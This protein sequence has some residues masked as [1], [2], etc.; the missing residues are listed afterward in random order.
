VALRTGGHVFHFVHD[1]PGI[2]RLAREEDGAFAERYR[3]V[4]NRS[5]RMAHLA[6]S[7]QLERRVR[8]TFTT[9]WIA[10]ERQLATLTALENDTRL[11]EAALATRRHEAFA[12][13]A[14]AGP[15]YFLDSDVVPRAARD[16]EPSLA[17][18]RDALTQARGSTFL[19]ARIDATAEAL[20]H[21]PVPETGTVDDGALSAR[22][23]RG[24]AA[25]YEDLVVRRHAL[26]ILRDAIALRSD[27]VRDTGLALTAAERA[28]LRA[29]RDVLRQRALTLLD[30]RRP[31]AGY[32]LVVTLARLAAVDRS[33]GAARWIVLDT[34][35][36]DAVV[37]EAHELA[38]H[39]EAVA[40]AREVNRHGLARARRTLV[41]ASTGERLPE[42]ELAGL[43][44]AANRWLE[45]QRSQVAPGRMRLA[46]GPFVPARAMRHTRP[47]LPWSDAV[48]A[49]VALA[50]RAAERRQRARL[51]AQYGYD[52][53]RRNCVTALFETLAEAGVGTPD[54]AALDF[55]P[56]VA[57]ARLARRLPVR[58]TTPL[59]SRREVA[60]AALRAR[61]PAL[62]VAL[63]ESNTLTAT[64]YRRN[65]DD[66][67]FLFFT[68]G[69]L[70]A[71][72]FLG[73]VNLGLGLGATAAGLATLP[74]DAGHLLSAGARG[75]LF[76]LP[77]LGFVNI[78]KGSY[79]HL[80]AD[81][82]PEA[83][84]PR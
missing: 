72:P 30:S 69:A 80:P 41:A 52:L 4:Q 59:P 16:T 11:A 24:V 28:A 60:L 19:A 26:E 82:L 76:S 25:G 17:R 56:V 29:L 62:L 10:Q 6:A 68:D 58:E 35:P 21:L 78:R 13:I 46:A 40:A 44:Q 39:A 20:A 64:A 3:F 18:L 31:D 5:I 14:L 51:Q 47:A 49:Q 77:E 70:A 33:L 1:A 23:R 66:S 61:E 9:R 7:G 42:R 48:L 2:V 22:R 38:R 53:V 32:V 73:A 83:S 36:D 75:A 55:I 67:L 65:P 79:D 54:G 37:L 12:P 50:T 45:A 8:T 15:G 71:R 34:F 74:F 57:H 84:F 27:A 63:R 81:G 43:E